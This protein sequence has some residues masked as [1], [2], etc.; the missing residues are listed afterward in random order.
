MY[1]AHDAFACAL[2]HPGL[3][4]T[5]RAELVE[6]TIGAEAPGRGWRS[7]RKSFAIFRWAAKH[8]YVDRSLLSA[9]L[10]ER[11]DLRPP[12]RPKNP[13][14]DP[15]PQGARGAI[16]CFAVVWPRFRERLESERKHES[17]L[18]YTGIAD[19]GRRHFFAF[20]SGCKARWVEDVFDAMEHVLVHGDDEAKNLVVVG[21]MEAVQTCA[22]P[23]GR[24]GDRYEAALRPC[25]AKAWADLIEGWT[26]EEIRTLDAWRKK[27]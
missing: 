8:G 19:M 15:H 14:L 13:A 27:A 2:V 6:A 7:R 4:P 23:A 12:R 26:G 18:D 17:W 21:L 5:V 16:A 11:V 25:A 22:Y 3:A 1:D 24:A 20:T 10:A 9:P